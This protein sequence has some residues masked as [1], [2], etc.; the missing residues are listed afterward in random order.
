MGEGFQLLEIILLAMIAA[1]IVLR[2]RSVLGRR[3][4]H[5]QRPPEDTAGKPVSKAAKSDL[6]D[7]PD[8][9]IPINDGVE[10]PPAR[11]PYDN[12]PKGQVLNQMRK[13]DRQF[14]PETFAAQA[15]MAYETIVIA[16]ASGDRALLRDL[17]SEEVYRNF[18]TAIDDRE[19]DDLSMT[20]DILAMRSVEITDAVLEGKN[21]EI[22][23][24]FET[25]M[26][27][28]TKNSEGAVVAGDPH[29]HVVKEQWTF[30][31]TL[32]SRNPNWLL[33]TTLGA[34]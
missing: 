9:V 32:Q 3:M 8:N 27:S 23:V 29:P 20:T 30:A 18:E 24:R 17:L 33:I 12:S 31:R 22:P 21:A 7:I 28:V 2:L 34:D 14:N 26:I 5:E 4:G 1:F 13:L 25:D 19:R 11:L 16:F 6:D 10:I 15:G